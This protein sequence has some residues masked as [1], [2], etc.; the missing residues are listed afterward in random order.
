MREFAKSVS[1]I[2]VTLLNL[3]Q[4]ARFHFVLIV[5]NAISDFRLGLTSMLAMWLFLLIDVVVFPATNF[6]M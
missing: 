6:F 1:P 2:L 5:T 4:L 3:L